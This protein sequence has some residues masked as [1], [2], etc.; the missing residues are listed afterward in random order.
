MKIFTTENLKAGGQV[1]IGM[2]VIGLFIG[3]FALTRS[4]GATSPPTTA[5]LQDSQFLDNHYGVSATE[6]CGSGADDYLRSVAKWD[7][8]WDAD[9]PRFDQHLTHVDKPGVLV[10]LSRKAKLANGFGAFQHITLYCDYDT[11]AQKVDGYE[12]HP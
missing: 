5:Q 3:L 4:S 6:D 12:L 9:S 10:L 8:S 7:F 1:A 11:Q 2:C